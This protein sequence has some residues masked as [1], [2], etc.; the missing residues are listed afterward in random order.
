[1]T[2]AAQPREAPFVR[3]GPPDVIKHLDLVHQEDAVRPTIPIW[4]DH[5]SHGNIIHCTTSRH[6]S[7]NASE[8]LWRK[9]LG[10]LT[11]E[12]HACV[13]SATIILTRRLVVL[14]LLPKRSHLNE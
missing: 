8:L 7:A 13:N 9:L 1:M 11:R 14:I 4:L 5:G 3:V 6:G 2:F 12:L 10:G